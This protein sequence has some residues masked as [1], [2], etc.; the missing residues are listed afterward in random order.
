MS[1]SKCYAL[2]KDW[3]PC[4]NYARP[5]EFTCRQH[6]T[7][8]ADSKAWVIKMLY[9]NHRFGFPGI[10]R[11]TLEVL[12]EGIVKPTRSDFYFSLDSTRYLRDEDAKKWRRGPREVP[13]KAPILHLFLRYC[14]DIALSDFPANVEISVYYNVWKSLLSYHRTFLSIDSTAQE[15]TLQAWLEKNVA[16]ILKPWFKNNFECLNRANPLVA[17]SR[18]L[19]VRSDPNAY[20]PSAEDRINTPY[21]SRMVWKAFIMNFLEC[22]GHI[23]EIQQA[24]WFTEGN[25]V[26]DPKIR[27]WMKSPF[28]H[29]YIQE[30]RKVW[31]AYREEKRTEALREAKVRCDTYKED[32]MACAWHPDRM[33]KWCLDLEEYEDLR[34]HWIGV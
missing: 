27:T 6:R 2:C 30:C 28:Y 24:V 29:I 12:R 21:G 9:T 26:F 13:L 8:F 20:P 23:D 31:S 32:L 19:S 10:R 17:L 5:D 22:Y 1:C 4:R 7:F 18:L 14:P 25:E 16:V 11:H 33:V 34:S 15:E 3:K